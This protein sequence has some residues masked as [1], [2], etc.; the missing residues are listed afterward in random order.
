MS[1]N[2]IAYIA[3]RSVSTVIRAIHADK[4]EGA[5]MRRHVWYI[6]RTDFNLNAAK[7]LFKGRGTKDYAVELRNDNNGATHRVVP[8]RIDDD[9]VI[10]LTKWQISIAKQNLRSTRSGALKEGIACQTN[11]TVK[12]YIRRQ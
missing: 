10:Y 8:K 2:D 7:T 6:P 3:D 11:L 5:F 9:G 1:V 12:E 4:F